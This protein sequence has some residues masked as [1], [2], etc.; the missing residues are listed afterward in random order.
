MQTKKGRKKGGERPKRRQTRQ[1]LEIAN[2]QLTSELGKSKAAVDIVQ[3]ELGKTRLELQMRRDE[4][5]N[6]DFKRGNHSSESGQGALSS[7][8]PCMFRSA[9]IQKLAVGSLNLEHLTPHIGVD[10]SFL[11]VDHA[12]SACQEFFLREAALGFPHCLPM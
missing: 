10:R 12:C 4:M 1:D 11:G 5:G 7:P 8:R 6:T 9:L 3:A 2:Q